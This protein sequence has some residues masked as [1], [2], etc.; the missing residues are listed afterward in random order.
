MANMLAPVSFQP[1]VIR[2]P[3][4]GAVNQ[5]I[6]PVN[7][8]FDWS[9]SPVSFLSVN[10]GRSS[11]PE[12]ESEILDEVGSYGRQL[13]RIGEALEVLVNHL[14][15]AKLSKDE[16]AALEAFSVQMRDI[17]KVKKRAAR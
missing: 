15:R 11:A 7:F 1:P 14:S 10:V 4:S 6:L 9:K 12:V 13:G 2:M 17:A 3:W 16:I 8:A 5:S